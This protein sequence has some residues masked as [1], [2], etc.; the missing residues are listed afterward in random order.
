M[1]RGLNG[2]P[3]HVHYIPQTDDWI[4]FEMVKEQKLRL[5]QQNYCS[6]TSLLSN[7]SGVMN[8]V[9]NS[10]YIIKMT[11]FLEELIWTSFFLAWLYQGTKNNVKFILGLGA[12]GCLLQFQHMKIGKLLLTLELPM[13]IT[14]STTTT[15]NCNVLL[16]PEVW[17]SWRLRNVIPW[18]LECNRPLQYIWVCKNK[19][20]VESFVH[21]LDSMVWPLPWIETTSKCNEL[22]VI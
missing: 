12:H 5:R 18:W 4:E 22:N 20:H 13:I 17:L 9:T 14:W 7:G 21:L 16:E 2:V 11:W 8:R 6:S 1:K 19:N 3:L 10:T 15:R